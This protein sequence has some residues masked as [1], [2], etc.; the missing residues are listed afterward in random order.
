MKT[1][2]QLYRC[3]AMHILFLGIEHASVSI[4][5][6]FGAKQES[7]QTRA[8]LSIYFI[9]FPSSTKSLLK[10]I[11]LHS[12]YTFNM[13]DKDTNPLCMPHPWHNPLFGH[14]QNLSVFSFFIKEALF[15]YADTCNAW[16]TTSSI[17]HGSMY[18]TL[19]TGTYAYYDL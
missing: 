14:F 3:K 18:P 7:F 15:N 2:Y 19:G 5:N 11:K 1:F 9:S 13:D 8:V 10:A 12:I 16:V 17:Y 4:T 6:I